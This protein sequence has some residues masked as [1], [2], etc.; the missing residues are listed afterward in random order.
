MYVYIYIYYNMYIYVHYNTYIYIYILLYIYIYI[1]YTLFLH[2]IYSACDM[3]G[4]LDLMAQEQ[5]HVQIGP[6]CAELLPPGY[7]QST[8][9]TPMCTLC[10]WI[11]YGY[12]MDNLWKIY[13]KSLD[14]V[15]IPSGNSA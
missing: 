10:I 6:A 4:E 11:I 7:G 2:Q 15:D 5:R 9:K 8:V 3:L 13:G 1:L 14:M 12:S